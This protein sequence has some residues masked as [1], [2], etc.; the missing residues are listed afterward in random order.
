MLGYLTKKRVSKKQNHA[1][2]L[3][4]RTR[5]NVTKESLF[6]GFATYPHELSYP[7]VFFAASE[8]RRGSSCFDLTAS[9]TDWSP[10]GYGG[11]NMYIDGLRGAF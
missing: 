7:G 9:T 6:F 4:I 8:P 10:P 1:S 5:L 2:V 11:T 3:K